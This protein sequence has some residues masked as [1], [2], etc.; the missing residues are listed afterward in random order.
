M[1]FKKSSDLFSS[2]NAN[3]IESKTT[4]NTM[5][6]NENS[7]ELNIYSISFNILEFE[8]KPK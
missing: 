6:L 2:N 3:A 4:K 7:K 1:A 5:K 8:N